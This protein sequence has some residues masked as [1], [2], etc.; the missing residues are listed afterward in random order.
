[1]SGWDGGVMFLRLI[2]YT[3]GDT[4]RASDFL[5]QEFARG[6]VSIKKPKQKATRNV[7]F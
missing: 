6:A 5:R 4:N 7:A 1:V 2:V 3:F